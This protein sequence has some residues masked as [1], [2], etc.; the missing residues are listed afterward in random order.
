MYDILKEY[1]VSNG[2]QHIQFTNEHSDSINQISK[3]VS[4]LTK[5]V[6]DSI[7]LVALSDYLKDQEFAKEQYESLV[8]QVKLFY[9]HK[10]Y[11]EVKLLHA[12]VTN[13]TSGAREL[14][15]LVDT[16]WII[17]EKELR[18]LIYE[19]QQPEF[20]DVKGLIENVLTGRNRPRSKYFTLMNTMLVAINTLVFVYFEWI[21]SIYSSDELIE[22]GSIYWP[23][24]TERREYYRIFTYMFIHFGVSHLLNNMVVLIFIGNYIERAFGSGKYVLLYLFSGLIAGLSSLGYNML[25]NNLVYSAGA[26]GA[27]FGIVGAML[28][29]V[30]RNKG[31]FE[32]IGV[33]Q[34]ILFLFL[35]LYSG[36]MNQEVDNVAHIGGL[37]AGIILAFFLYKGKK[38]S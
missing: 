24:I 26:S 17:D 25:N 6:D 3:K 4:F 11:Q 9:F 19:N 5:M 16:Y 23:L 28:F 8:R 38:I 29:V 22:A 14:F 33:K 27:V 2:Y 7:Y 37:L 12:I 1:L 20:A 18:L 31:K 21:S 10:G 34:M 35:S 13:N 15:G 30:V 32:D 36:I